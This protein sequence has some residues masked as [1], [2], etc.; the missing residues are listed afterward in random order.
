[1]RLILKQMCFKKDVFRLVTGL[2][3]KPRRTSRVI[4]PPSE[5]ASPSSSSLIVLLLFIE[6]NYGRFLKIYKQ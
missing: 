2:V 5:N 4:F 6:N 3:L 1:M